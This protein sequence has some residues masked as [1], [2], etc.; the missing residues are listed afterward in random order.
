VCSLLCRPNASLRE[1]LLAVQGAGRDGW[2]CYFGRPGVA[3]GGGRRCYLRRPSLLLAKGGY[4]TLGLRCC[5]Q[6]RA[7]FATGGCQ[8]CYIRHQILLL[9]VPGVATIAHICLLQSD[10]FSSMFV[11]CYIS[12]T[13]LLQ[14]SGEV[15]GETP[16]SS[17]FF[18][19][20]ID[21]CFLLH[22]VAAEIF[23]LLPKVFFYCISYMTSIRRSGTWGWGIRSRE[24]S[25]TVQK[26]NRRK[27]DVV[28]K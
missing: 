28:K 21:N 27:S 10:E 15:S 17:D 25:S 3:T 24:T 1:L 9:T 6:R 26:F 22:A 8:L 23:I 14:I 2:C 18:F 19:Y 20:F 12:I 11:F 16:A 5:Y 13:F 7:A 4:S